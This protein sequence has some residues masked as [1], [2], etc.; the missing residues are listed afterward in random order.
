M[1]VL[2]WLL[3]SILFS[4]QNFPLEIEFQFQIREVE[5]GRKGT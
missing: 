4:A 2:L 5:G 1:R 3:R